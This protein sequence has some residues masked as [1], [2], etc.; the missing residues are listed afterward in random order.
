MNIGDTWR[1]DPNAL[2]NIA[3]THKKC[4]NCDI[5]KHVCNFRLKRG[6]IYSWCKECERKKALKHYYN[7]TKVAYRCIKD[8]NGV[9]K[10]CPRCNQKKEINDVSFYQKDIIEKK[11]SWCKK[12]KQENNNIRSRERTKAHKEEKI[13]SLP[14]YLK[15]CSKCNEIKDVNN[16]YAQNNRHYSPCKKCKQKLDASN[17]VKQRK[18]DQRKQRVKNDSVLKLRLRVSSTIANALKASGGSKFGKSILEKLPYS[19][20]E[21]LQHLESQFESW[22]NWG[23]HGMYKIGGP[24]TWHLDHIISQSKLPYDSMSHPNFHKC[25]ALNNLRPLEASKNISDGAR[26]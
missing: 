2:Y 6:K 22:M 8:Y 17:Y 7:N 23:N 4:T 24:K 5:E 18:Y 10:I 3:L 15:K 13:N 9:V 16:F 19:I 21:L 26:N 14:N 11:V 12:C 25:W 1:D 20:N